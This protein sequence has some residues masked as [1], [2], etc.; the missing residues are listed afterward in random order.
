MRMF[1]KGVNRW[2][3]EPKMSEVTGKWTRLDDVGLYGL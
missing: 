2:V 3:F 1:E